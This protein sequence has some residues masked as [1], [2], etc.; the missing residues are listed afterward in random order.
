MSSEEEVG[1]RRI[2]PQDTSHDMKV[3]I[4]IPIT[5]PF[6]FLGNLPTDYAVKTAD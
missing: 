5:P 1:R 2:R 6:R 4:P 3:V